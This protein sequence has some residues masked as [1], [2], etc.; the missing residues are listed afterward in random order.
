MI[1]SQ[2]PIRMALA[3]AVWMMIPMAAPAQGQ[4]WVTAWGTSQ[5]G[6]GNARISNATVRMLARV[7]IPGES[8]RIRLDNTFGASPVT[9]GKATIGPRVR[10]P[11]LAAGMITP[12]TFSGKEMVTIPAGESVVSDPVALRVEAQQDLAVSL[13]VT[14]AETRPS[15]HLSAFVTSYLT[16]NGAGDHSASADGRP[17]TGRTTSAFWL[18]AIDVRPPDAGASAVVAFGDSITDGTCST[19]DAHERWEDVVAKRLAL[20]HVVRRAVV[21]EGIAGN[22]LSG[23]VQPAA[24]SPPG[25]ERLDRDVLSH[26]GVSHVVLFMGT[27]DIRREASAAQVIEGMSIIAGR[28]KAKGIKVIGAT[29]VPRHYRAPE[30]GNTGWSEGKTR[31]KNEVNEWIRQGKAFDAVLDFD[32]VVR[33]PIDPNLL[34]P[35]YN[36]DGIHP[37]PLGY[38][39]MGKSVDLGLF[40]VR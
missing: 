11:A 22:T 6:L 30:P 3:A 37:T 17:F 35:A 29:I 20:Q 19:V 28:V 33:S 34:S 12:V 32:N 8:V 36:C 13:F 26:A 25:I 4:G 15:Q 5:Q 9:F 31:T 23:K 2:R 7:T 21:N 1:D 18:K 16:E 38:F 14:G 40:D 27:N 39:Q 24:D 10:G